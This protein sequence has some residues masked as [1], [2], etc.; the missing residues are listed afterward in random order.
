MVRLTKWWAITKGLAV[1][2]GMEQRK[3][4]PQKMRVK[5]L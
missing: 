2:N 4:K 3:E 1:W 5:S